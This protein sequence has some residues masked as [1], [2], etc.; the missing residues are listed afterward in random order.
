MVSCVILFSIQ[1]FTMF[2]IY[3]GGWRNLE[4]REHIGMISNEESV[5]HVGKF[6]RVLL[7]Y[8][9]RRCLLVCDD[10]VHEGGS[11][12]SRV[13]QPHGLFKQVGTFSYTFFKANMEQLTNFRLKTT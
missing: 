2:D 13:T 5:G 1:S 6:L 12:G 10:V 11:T 7:C 8:F 9:H 3:V 4:M